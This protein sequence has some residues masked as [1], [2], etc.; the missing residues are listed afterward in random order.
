MHFDDRL[1]TVL[2]LPAS[3]EAMARIQFRQLVDLLGAG[4]DKL[5]SVPVVSEALARLQQL[6]SVIPA[7]DRARMLR[8][9]MTRLA[10]PRIVAQLASAEPEVASAAIAAADLT[11]SE[12]AE[13]I[14]ALPVRARGILRH[15]RDLSSRVEALLERLGI[16]DR[17][18]PPAAPS[19]EDRRGRPELVVFEGGGAGPMPEA[20]QNRVSHPQ[21][22]R[23]GAGIGAIVRRI[24]EFRKARA[25]APED[26]AREGSP[27]SG[28]VRLPRSVNV[29]D[30][31]TDDQARI[32]WAD[33]FL[34]PGLVGHRFAGE[35]GDTS[36]AGLNSAMRQ[37]QPLRGA[38]VN[39]DGAAGLSGHWRLDALPRFDAGGRF[40]GYA[41]RLRRTPV[42][43]RA[44][45]ESTGS[46]GDSMRQVLHELRT[47]A[48][49]IQIAAEIIQQQ[50]YGP[51]PH[52]YRALAAAIA[53]DTAQILAGFDEL[54]RLVK[55]E[56]GALKPAPG[57]CDLSELVVETVGRLRA[58]TDPRDSGFAM[59]EPLQRLHVGIDCEDAL[60]LVWRLL[61]A[62]ASATAPGEKLTL[63]MTENEKNAVLTIELPETLAARLEEARNSGQAIEAARSLSAG[64]F[65][66]GFTLRLAGAE[67]AAAGGALERVG[68]QFRLSLPGLTPAAASHTQA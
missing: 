18:L 35:H 47:P 29:L 52:E 43:A 34:A 63:G 26:T 58:W 53:G 39:L 56:S 32:S 1:A 40:L 65:G 50:L 57:A 61:A 24:E 41:G 55:I 19:T 44:E 36:A 64:M 31:T 11:E 25:T 48:N 49:A 15:R 68:A 51:A 30:F 20:V 59:P 28:V 33:T 2:R 23:E 66:L 16:T 37:R 22:E 67:A 45:D 4:S 6:E 42:A 7:A 13:L 5:G 10:N 3:G 60:L 54:D 9:P 8:E 46:A 38:L 12:W 14:P 62:V 17:G 21:D 27:A